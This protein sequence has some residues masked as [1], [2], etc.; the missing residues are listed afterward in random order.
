LK[1]KIKNKKIIPPQLLSFLLASFSFFF[2]TRVRA[3]I[4]AGGR[5][6]KENKIGSRERERE[7][8]R[9]SLDGVSLLVPLLVF[10][11]LVAPPLSGGGEEVEVQL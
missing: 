6:V 11:H 1:K 2:F 10:S 8:E 9:E 4:S 3:G 7:R 5:G